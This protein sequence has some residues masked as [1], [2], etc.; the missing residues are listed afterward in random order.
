MNQDH[1]NLHMEAQ[2]V[3]RKRI[4]LHSEM[5]EGFVAKKARCE[6]LDVSRD[7]VDRMDCLVDVFKRDRDELLEDLI[8]E[9]IFRLGNL[10]ELAKEMNEDQEAR[11][12]LKK[13]HKYYV[14]FPLWPLPNLKPK[15]ERNGNTHHSRFKSEYRMKGM[16]L[17]D[18]ATYVLHHGL[19]PD[20][21][22][23]EGPVGN[24]FFDTLVKVPSWDQKE[25][26]RNS[27]PSIFVHS[28]EDGYD[29]DDD[30]VAY[31]GAVRMEYSGAVVRVD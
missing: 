1:F 7:T 30:M 19:Y 25:A 13:T 10:V 26:F 18:N 11:I 14:P 20:E 23:L 29:T 12:G 28:D 3:Y 27:G 5:I 15:G 8:A 9:Q 21:V 17:P 16:I 22:L 6:E 31:D 2:N 24:P 4:C